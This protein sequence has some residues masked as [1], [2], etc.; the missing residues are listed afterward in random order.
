[1]L[2]IDDFLDDDQCA[3]LRQRILNAPFVSGAST[4][5]GMAANVKKNL[6][7][8]E[9][10]A[11][12]VVDEI[13]SLILAHPG[14]DL[15]AMPEKLVGVIVNRYDEGME[16]GNHSDSPIMEGVRCDL[17][18][19]LFLEDHSNYDGGELVLEQEHG[20][21]KVKPKIGSIFVYS[22]GLTHRVAKV[23]RGSR[24]A[25]VGWIKSRIRD[26]GRRKVL[27]DLNAVLGAYM[28]KN[29]H[30]AVADLQLK[31]IGD[32]IRMWHE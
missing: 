23:T 29:G 1:M 12:K 5:G 20:L 2:L 13:K 21:I 4:A 14:V 19:T 11:G 3:R 9:R 18:F 31:I 28:E 10:K 27:R 24:L 22:T 15:F 17:S 26:E 7:L 25:C 32:L 30:D 6:Q 16:Y 8:D